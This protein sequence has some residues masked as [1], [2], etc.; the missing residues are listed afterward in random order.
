MMLI[1]KPTLVRAIEGGSMGSTHV[2]PRAKGLCDESVLSMAQEVIQRLSRIAKQAPQDHR[3]PD[4][5]GFCISLMEPSQDEAK[6]ILCRAHSEGATH[7]DLC[8]NYIAAAAIRFG[9]WWDQDRVSFKD[10]SLATGRM[11]Y[12]LQDLRDLL[13]Y[14]GYLGRREALFAAVPGEQHV[15]GITMAADMMRGKGWDIDLQIGRSEAELCQIAHDGAYPIVALSASGA[16]YVAALAGTI[17]ELRMAAPK[18]WIFVGGHIAALEPDIAKRT[19]AD[20]AADDIDSCLKALE[21][22]YQS[23]SV[24]RTP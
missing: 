17:V 1:R 15:L 22:L 6:L 4:I 21:G 19:G 23:A 7:Q 13:P 18:S 10:M 5:D 20:A 2:H 9:E 3:P 12:F 8:V 16:D 14:E 11:M 24:S